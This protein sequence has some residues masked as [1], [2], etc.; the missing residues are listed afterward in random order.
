MCRAFA[1]HRIAAGGGGRI[2]SISSGSA[3]SPRPEG[4][5]YAASKAAVE[6]LSKTLALELGPHGVQRERRRP[7]LHRRPRVERRLPEPRDRRVASVARPR[8]SRSARAG[9]PADIAAGGALPVLRRG[10]ARLRRRPRRRRRL[11]R[12]PLRARPRSADGE[13]RPRRDHEPALARER[14]GDRGHRPAAR[15]GVRARPDP[16]PEYPSA[17]RCPRSPTRGPS[18]RWV[19]LL[20][21]A[22]ILFD[23]G[24]LAL[25]R[26]LAGVAAPALDPGDERRRRPAREPRRADRAP[27]H[28]RHD[29]ERRPRPPARRV[30]GARDADVREGRAALPGRPARPPLAAPRGRGGRGQGGGRGRGGA[31][32]PRGV[33]PAARAR[34]ARDRRRPHRRRANGGRR[35]TPTRSQGSTASTPSCP[36]STP[37][38]WR[39]PTPPR[40]RVSST[41]AGSAFC[42]SAP[43]SSTS[44]GVTWSTRPRSPPRSSPAACAA[45]RSTSSRPSRR[46]TSSPFWDL[47]NV[48]VS[49]HS[50]ST[51]AAENDRIVEIFCENL[52]AYLAGRPLRNV[53]DPDLLY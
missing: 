7:G 36:G 32:R 18:E 38:S 44:P 19:E 13:R 14:R 42:P 33:T 27:R 43:S 20:E 37:S 21:S 35:R 41:P 31:D 6:T 10:G 53:L 34:R 39:R 49:P 4:A 25:R 3:R 11:A 8:R 5:A 24:P 28:R 48:L 47:P 12:R 30:R 1:R 9:E 52:H 15:R 50:A 40:P 45:L 17:I 26:R 2:V 22:E 29:R 16:A 23:F 51:V 46:P